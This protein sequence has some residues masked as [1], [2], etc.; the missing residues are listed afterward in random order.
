MHPMDV[1]WKRAFISILK[2][3]A[4]IHTNSILFLTDS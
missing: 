2:P 4:N 1:N 3:G